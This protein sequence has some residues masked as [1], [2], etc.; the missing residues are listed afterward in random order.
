[1]IAASVPMTIPAMAPGES[2][3]LSAATGTS[4]VIAPPVVWT[5]ARKGW[6]VVMGTVVTVKLVGLTGAE[7]LV[8]GTTGVK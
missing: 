3:P 4:G 7:K 2:P 6:V 8:A 5:G 1:M